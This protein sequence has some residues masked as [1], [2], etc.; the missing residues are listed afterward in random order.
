[1]R[2]PHMKHWQA[3]AAEWLSLQ[4]SAVDHCC[5]ALGKFLVTYLIGCD[6]PR[7]PISFLTRPTP[8]PIFSEVL[9]Q[10]KTQGAIGVLSIGEVV[11][12]NYVSD[13]L[14]WVL[15]DKLSLEGDYDHRVIPHEL[16]NPVARLTKTGIATP[17]ETTKAALSIRYIKEL[18]LM[19]AEG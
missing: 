3:Y 2:D 8:K 9:V 10:A 4:K 14:D 6:L 19:L 16:H 13:F 7:N 1:M 11:Q 15:A 12:N 5:E 17:M 18:R